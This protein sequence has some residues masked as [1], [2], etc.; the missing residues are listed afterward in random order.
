ML[1]RADMEAEVMVE[2]MAEDMAE[3]ATEEVVVEEEEA[4]AEIAMRSQST[5][6]VL[7]VLQAHQALLVTREIPELLATLALLELRVILVKMEVPDLKAK[8][9]LQEN[10]AMME[11]LGNRG[12]LEKEVLWL[13]SSFNKIANVNQIFFHRHDP[14]SFNSV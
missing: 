2:G 10:L 14:V 9:V 6:R 5:F 11:F 12:F 1:R 7:R 4:M 3:A 8:E 13:S